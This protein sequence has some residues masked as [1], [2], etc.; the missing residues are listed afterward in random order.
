MTEIEQTLARKKIEQKQEQKQEQK[1]EQEQDD[2]D[3]V[4]TINLHSR[5]SIYHR[6]RHHHH[7][8]G[9]VCIYGA[10]IEF[11]SSVLSASVG[12]T[13]LSD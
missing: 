12:V 8:H 2:Y 4:E 9:D 7:H 1:K 3:R 10:K 5:T 13:F 11:V 6:H